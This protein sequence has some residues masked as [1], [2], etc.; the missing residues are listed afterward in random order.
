MIFQF[1]NLE[2]EKN[3]NY[4]LET[5]QLEQFSPLV[6]GRFCKNLFSGLYLKMQRT[7]EALMLNFQFHI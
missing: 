7:I 5:M 1:G 4:L 3:A 6:D 2:F